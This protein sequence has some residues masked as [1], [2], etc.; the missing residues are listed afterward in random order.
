MARDIAEIRRDIEGTRGRLRDTAEA[1]GWKADVP[2][3]ARDIVRET[4][5]V[6]RER[7]GSGSSSTGSASHGSS[8]SLTDRLSSVASTIGGRA[9]SAKESV[10]SGA[11]SVGERAGSVVESVSQ[12]ASSVAGTVS[13]AA[14]SAA[15]AAGSAV[16]AVGAAKGKVAERLPTTDDVRTGG[17]Q[18]VTFARSNPVGLAVGALVLGVAA[19]ALLPSTRVED[20]HIGAVADDVKQRGAELGQEVV[21]RGGETVRAA[22]AGLTTDEEG[23][24]DALPPNSEG[25]LYGEP[26]EQDPHFGEGARG[27]A[28]ERGWRPG[29]GLSGRGPI[30]EGV[31]WRRRR[32][33]ALRVAAALACVGA[34][35]TGCSSE[36][37]TG[38][39]EDIETLIHVVPE[40]SRCVHDRDA[41]TARFDVRL[42][43]TGEDERI[44]TVTPVRRFADRDVDTSLDGFEVT[45]PGDG[46]ASGG[47]LVD[48]VSDDLKD[49]LVRLDGGPPIQV[50]LQDAD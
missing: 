6:V 48:G 50:D 7:V 34:L 11:G 43:N 3:R 29:G 19:G 47:T 32:R 13:D 25:P 37:I 39:P 8:G 30:G 9:G 36:D 44:V 16:G 21:E 12:G 40:G 15:E 26:A 2:A 10:S 35:L 28:L 23:G 18:V 20:E 22:T 27:R 4:A 24:E 42:R 49:C 31:M 17:R 1:I 14:G 46:E 33:P 41:D 38:E 5:G 45:V